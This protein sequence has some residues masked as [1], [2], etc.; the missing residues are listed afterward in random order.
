M[1]H[2]ETNEYIRQDDN[3]AIKV[4]SN[5]VLKPYLVRRFSAP[6][7]VSGNVADITHFLDSAHRT[8]K[9]DIE[10]EYDDNSKLSFIP[11]GKTTLAFRGDLKVSK[12][13]SRGIAA[14]NG[15]STFT[16]GYGKSYIK[17]SVPSPVY[18]YIIKGVIAN[19]ENR[20]I[21]LD[22]DWKDRFRN[23]YAEKKD[24]RTTFWAKMYSKIAGTDQDGDP[25]RDVTSEMKSLR[26][27]ATGLARIGIR[28]I[29]IHNPAAKQAQWNLRFSIQKLEKVQYTIVKK[30]PSP[31]MHFALM[32]QC[33]F[34]EDDLP[35]SRL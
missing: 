7:L 13:F 22:R 33:H 9:I 28:L 3:G 30:Q 11:I 12:K 10:L 29:R 19:L 5:G 4:K 23:L 21:G 8:E 6:T 35:E 25:I 15:S 17:L 16:G 24:G 31:A 27:D 32:A 1:V 14:T 2:I 26:A 18:N 20:H 34:S